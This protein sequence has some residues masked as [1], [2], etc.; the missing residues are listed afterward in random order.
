MKV[1]KEDLLTQ[2]KLKELLHYDPDTGLLTWR[3]RIGIVAMSNNLIRNM[4]V[5]Q[6]V[7]NIIQMMH[8]L[9]IV[10]YLLGWFWVKRNIASWH[11][12]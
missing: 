1:N 4:L 2:R 5:K 7:I 9:I 10:L 12:V 3:S 8:M 11:I 6:Q